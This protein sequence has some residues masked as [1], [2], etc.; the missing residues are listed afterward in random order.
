MITINWC[1]ISAFYPLLLNF[2]DT[3]LKVDFS[4]IATSKIPIRGKGKMQHTP[5]STP[6]SPG[7]STASYGLSGLTY[8]VISLP[9]G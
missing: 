2:E 6:D 7:S 9:S 1:E 4:I 3:T 8:T 5:K